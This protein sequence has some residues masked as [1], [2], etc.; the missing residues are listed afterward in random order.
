MSNVILSVLDSRNLRELKR[1]GWRPQKPLEEGR[2]RINT[3]LNIHILVN[4]AQH[5]VCHLPQ[6]EMSGFRL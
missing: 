1:G 4:P 3:L 5:I 2:H 6:A